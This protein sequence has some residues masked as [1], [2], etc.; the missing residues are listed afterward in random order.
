MLYTVQIS[1]VKN[2]PSKTHVIDIAVQS[3]KLPWNIFAPTWDMVSN[4]KAGRLSESQYT[5]MYIKLM[6]TRYKENK[7]IFRQLIEI[8]L[9][10][11]VALA[12]YCPPGTFCHRHIL[13]DI[14]LKIEPRLQYQEE[15]TKPP[16]EQITIF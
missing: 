7:N 9:A 12:C 6:R 10:E 8:A 15:K 5:D 13:K 16:V 2:L 14:L 1:Q 3:S 4:Y 11:N